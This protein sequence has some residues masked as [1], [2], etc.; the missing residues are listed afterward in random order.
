LSRVYD[1]V[2]ANEEVRTNWLKLYA[3]G[4]P[5]EN[6]EKPIVRALYCAVEGLSVESYRQC[7]CGGA[8]K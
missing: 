3:V 5:A 2:V 7:Y 4:G 1:Q 8:T 6:G